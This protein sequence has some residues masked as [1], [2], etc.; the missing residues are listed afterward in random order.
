MNLL[1]NKLYRL[2]APEVVCI[3]KGIAHKRY[4]FGCKVEIAA[5]TTRAKSGSCALDRGAV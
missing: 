5:T 2:H 3:S 4:E 1:E